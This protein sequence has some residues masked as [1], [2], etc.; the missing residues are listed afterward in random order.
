[1]GRKWNEIIKVPKWETPIGKLAF[2]LGVEDDGVLAS[3]LRSAYPACFNAR[4]AYDEG[5]PPWSALDVENRSV[6]EEAS[7]AYVSTE[8]LEYL[9]I[10]FAIFALTSEAS[11]ELCVP[12]LPPGSY[13]MREE[14][15]HDGVVYVVLGDKTVDANESIYAI[16]K[17]AVNW[18]A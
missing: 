9:S 12:L 5:L 7:P 16:R 13:A 15:E 3:M 18:S 2:V 1:M 4:D 14:F 8:A 6:C 11:A 10:E 17:D